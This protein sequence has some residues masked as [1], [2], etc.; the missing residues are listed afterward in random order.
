[1]QEQQQQQA[2]APAHTP[3]R[4]E[5]LHTQLAWQGLVQAQLRAAA[6][7]LLEAMLATQALVGWVGLGEPAALVQQ[8]HT[9]VAI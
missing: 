3:L 8:E 9:Q 1:L 5:E 7:M 6:L 2:A 4:W